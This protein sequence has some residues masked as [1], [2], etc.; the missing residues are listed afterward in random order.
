MKGELQMHLVAWRT[1]VE[2]AV[3][4]AQELLRNLS[5]GARLLVQVIARRLKGEVSMRMTLWRRNVTDDEDHHRN[6]MRETMHSNQTRDLKQSLK[7][8]RKHGFQAAAAERLRQIQNA[9]RKDD[10]ALRVSHWRTAVLRELIQSSEALEIQNAALQGKLTRIKEELQARP[11]IF[12]KGVAFERL[13]H[14][15]WHI[16]L[17]D[18]IQRLRGWRASMLNGPTRRASQEARLM[19]R[20]ADRRKQ[21]LKDD[22]E[23]ALRSQ[24]RMASL[25]LLTQRSELRQAANTAVQHEMSNRLYV[26]FASVKMHRMQQS[27]QAEM[28]LILDDLHDVNATLGPCDDSM[29]PGNNAGPPDGVPESVN[30]PNW[31]ADRLCLKEKDMARKVLFALQKVLLK[32]GLE[33]VSLSPTKIAH[34]LELLRSRREG[35]RRC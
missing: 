6:S 29:Q 19:Q 11:E 16:K 10:V 24:V 13:R 31:L 27:Q 22:K 32:H 33:G 23:H 5:I 21:K 3:M 30:T 20:A 7:S 8:Q 14:T 18:I 26:W 17:T 34:N 28:E 15:V 2:T 9:I 35:R 1:I 12:Q 25:Q 4:Q